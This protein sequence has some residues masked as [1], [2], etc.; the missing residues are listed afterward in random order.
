M[1]FD[2]WFSWWKNDNI[3]ESSSKKWDRL[4]IKVPKTTE[5]KTDLSLAPGIKS[6]WEEQMNADRKK[7]LELKKVTTTY[8]NDDGG[9]EYRKRLWLWKPGDD[10]GNTFWFDTIIN[11][12]LAWKDVKVSLSA[13]AYTSSPWYKDTRRKAENRIDTWWVL[14]TTS[15][16]KGNIWDFWY[17]VNVWWWLN[18]V[19]NL[20]LDGVQNQWHTIN[21]IWLNNSKYT[22]DFWVSPV[23]TGNIEWQLPLFQ[24]GDMKWSIYGDVW[25]Q[26]ALF[27]EY[28]KSQVYT[29]IW[30]KIDWKW[31]EFKGWYRAEFTELSDIGV[32]K[33]RNAP[34]DD[35][36]HW[37]AQMQLPIFDTGASLFSGVQVGSA[38]G[39]KWE[40]TVYS[41]LALKF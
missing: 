1:W 14:A 19:W 23:L 21:G 34:T 7:L 22:N 28:G 2:S 33:E 6:E 13:D 40:T 29:D 31:I 11:A 25:W 18:G 15:V 10:M 9:D 24:V 27:P 32:I 41:W 30:G 16:E 20:G 38:N 4:D 39:Q 26:L 12:E 36:S 8:R 5:G 35:T 17:T 3:Q 37:Y